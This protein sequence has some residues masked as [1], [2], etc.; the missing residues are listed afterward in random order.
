MI[1]RLG[2]PERGTGTRAMVLVDPYTW[3][4]CQCE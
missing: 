3:R 4:D 2:K 1:Y